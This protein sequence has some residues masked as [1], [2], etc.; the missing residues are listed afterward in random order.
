MYVHWE[1]QVL[2]LYSDT[3]QVHTYVYG[4]YTH[5]Y[6]L[7]HVYYWRGFIFGDVLATHQTAKFK[8]SPNLPAIRY[9]D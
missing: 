7:H 4:A 9:Y 6:A 3:L 5:G 2:L 8:S 1:V